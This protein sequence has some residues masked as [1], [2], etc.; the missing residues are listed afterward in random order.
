MSKPKKDYF[1][2]TLEDYQEPACEIC[3]HAEVP[4]DKKPC[5][6]CIHLE[7]PNESA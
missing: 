5:K 3:I 1:E 6:K 2:T 7:E 4:A